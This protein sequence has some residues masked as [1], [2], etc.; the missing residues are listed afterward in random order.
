MEKKKWITIITKHLGEYVR[1]T[2]HQFGLNYSG[3]KRKWKYFRIHQRGFF[4]HESYYV[5]FWLKERT[6]INTKVV[7]KWR[8]NRDYI[9]MVYC[10]IPSTFL[11][12]TNN[13]MI[14]CDLK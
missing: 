14:K 3:K 1:S 12:G 2:L 8:L 10:L 11:W 6:L 7:E 5:N 4:I 9:H 13:W